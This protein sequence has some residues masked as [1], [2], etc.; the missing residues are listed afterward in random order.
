MRI[1]KSL[2]KKKVIMGKRLLIK[3]LKKNYFLL[4]SGPYVHLLFVYEE[5]K[6]C[7]V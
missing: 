4:S 7:V 6:T 5:T 1:I 2:L 3:N